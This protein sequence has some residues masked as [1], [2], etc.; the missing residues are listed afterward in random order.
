MFKHIDKSLFVQTSAC[1]CEY[2]WVQLCVDPSNLCLYVCLG[3]DY[4]VFTPYIRLDVKTCLGPI[5][6][7]TLGANE[8]CTISCTMK[9]LT[10]SSVV[11]LVIKSGGVLRTIWSLTRSILPLQLP[12]RCGVHFTC[13][14]VDSKRA[15]SFSRWEEVLHRDLSTSR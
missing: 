1:W 8:R 14:K 2:I 4:S 11:A 10:T 13:I 3:P 9:P 12:C 7:H 15:G 5:L 6:L